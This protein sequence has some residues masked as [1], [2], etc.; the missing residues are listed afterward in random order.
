MSEG[1][2]ATVCMCL[3]ASRQAP[4]PAAERLSGTHVARKGMRLPSWAAAGGKQ[5]LVETEV[6]VTVGRVSFLFSV[7]LWD[8]SVEATRNFVSNLLL[9]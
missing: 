3:K 9:F 2:S 1:S 7:L 5:C 6:A 4:I 8:L